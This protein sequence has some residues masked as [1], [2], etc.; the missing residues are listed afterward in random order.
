MRSLGQW[1]ADPAAAAA[2]AR[3][4]AL[5]SPCSPAATQP[6]APCRAGPGSPHSPGSPGRP[7]PTM[8]TAAP[9]R[10][11][12]GRPDRVLGVFSRIA[13]FTWLRLKPVM[14]QM[15]ALGSPA[16]KK[17]VR[18]R[19]RSASVRCFVP[20]GGGEKKKKKR[21]DNVRGVR[22]ESG[23]RAEERPEPRMAW[24]GRGDRDEQEDETSRKRG[25]RRRRSKQAAPSSPGARQGKSDGAAIVGRTC[26]AV[27]RWRRGEASRAVSLAVVVSS[28][29]RTRDA[30]T[31][32]LRNVN[33]AVCNV[34][35]CTLL[36]PHKMG[37]GRAL[38]PLVALA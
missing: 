26:L 34:Y 21:R 35:V 4:T 15:R 5:S 32:R 22:R 18:A 2:W 31:R 19:R 38:A 9:D 20:I 14:W 6:C 3:R 12:G 7:A 33:N 13:S 24:T 29:A 27:C 37:P 11:R 30:T 8:A 25:K 28:L 1:A 10:R 16:S 36:R 23:R 17:S